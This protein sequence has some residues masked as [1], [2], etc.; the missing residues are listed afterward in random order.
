MARAKT[1]TITRLD[2]IIQLCREN[3]VS[4]III[5]DTIELELFPFSANING[6]GDVTNQSEITAEDFEKIDKQNEM[7]LLLHSAN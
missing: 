2:E 7:N 4:K 6:L 3:G 5:P 1:I